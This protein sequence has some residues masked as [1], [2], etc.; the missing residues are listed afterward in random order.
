MKRNSFFGSLIFT[1]G[2][3]ILSTACQENPPVDTV[4]LPT[5][6]VRTLAL[7]PT[8]KGRVEASIKADN[9]NFYS[10]LFETPTGFVSPTIKGNTASYTYADTGWFVVKFRAHVSAAQYSEIIDSVYIQFN[11]VSLKNGYQSP[12]SYAGYRLVWADEFNT[13]AL[14]LGNWSYETGTGQWGWGNNE[15]QYYHEGEKN[16]MVEGGKLTITAKQESAGGAQYTSA[17]LVTRAKKEFQYGRIDIRARLP[18]GQGLWPA[19]WMLGSNIGSVS[20]PACGE[21]DIMESV[22]QKPNEV[23]GAAHWGSS[24]PSTFNSKKFRLTVGDF[25]DSFF[26]YSILWQKDKIEWFVNESKYHTITPLNTGSIYPFNNPFFFI[27]NIAVGGNLPGSPDATT[28]FPQN[29]EVDYIRVF[30]VE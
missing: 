2:I 10:I 23:L 8:Q 26:V 9:A 12:E 3:L 17:R 7:S 14:D 6:L 21:I 1:L 27:F 24:V 13:N 5:N 11:L 25:S 28:R 29:M 22:G 30:Q 15:L 4:L 18:K 20:W 19:L 16:A